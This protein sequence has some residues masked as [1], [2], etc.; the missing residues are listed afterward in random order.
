MESINIELLEGTYIINPDV[1]YNRFDMVYG[2][3]KYIHVLQGNHEWSI[4]YRIENNT[5]YLGLYLVDM[6][7]EVFNLLVRF[8]F[9]QDRHISR[10][11]LKKSRNNYHGHIREGNHFRIELPDTSDS[12][13]MRLSKKRC[14]YRRKKRRL[15]DVGTVEY[16]HYDSVEA[17]NNI[18][19]IF[20]ELKYKTHGKDYHMSPEEYI[21]NYFVSDAYTINING[22][23]VAVL[24]SCEQCS[25]VYLENLSYDAEYEK[26][27]V[28]F[29]I[30]VYFLEEMIRK[31]KRH[32]YLGGGSYEYKKRFGS[33]EETVY[34]GYVYKTM[35]R[36]MWSVIKNRINLA[37]LRWS[38]N[39]QR[40]GLEEKSKG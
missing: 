31:G 30:Y 18:A 4:P 32:I 35:W 14:E 23:I 20:L 15:N 25:C 13:L 26:Y 38:D 10:I 33:I 19:A 29:Q 9:K 16:M 6:P 37:G 28:G 5:A 27:S 2:T 7:Q 8:V 1:I 39:A 22:K 36:K 34:D 24:F 17:L 3:R 40:R 12:L 11:Y 21:K